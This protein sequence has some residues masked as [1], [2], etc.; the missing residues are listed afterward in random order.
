M[1]IFIFSY[2]LNLF[3][4]LFHVITFSRSSLS[5]RSVLPVSLLCGQ[6]SQ[7]HEIWETM[8]LTLFRVV[9][10]HC[11]DHVVTALYCTA[12]ATTVF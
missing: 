4:Y 12:V 9:R 3:N 6:N 1:A 8:S 7:W 2:Q 11:R 10:V 5:N